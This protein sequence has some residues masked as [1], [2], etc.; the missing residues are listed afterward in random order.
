MIATYYLMF[1]SLFRSCFFFRFTRC[2]LT[3]RATL[4]RNNSRRGYLVSGLIIVSRKFQIY[5][6]IF[7][8]AFCYGKLSVYIVFSRKGTKLRDQSETKYILLTFSEA[9]LNYVW[10][11]ATLSILKHVATMGDQSVETLGSKIRF[12]SVF[13]T[14]S[15]LPPKTMLIF[16]FLRLHRPQRLHN[17]EL[18]G[19][20][21][22]RINARCK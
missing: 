9:K 8:Y 10:Y 21:D 19:R 6:Q 17:I 12:L 7:L 1:S 18:G 14:F 16:L 22:K 2:V 3:C 20:G 11:R 13:V 4:K 5:R 15:S